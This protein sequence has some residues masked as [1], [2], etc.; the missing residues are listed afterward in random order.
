M[1]LNLLIKSIYILPFFSL[2][3]LNNLSGQETV[4]EEAKVAVQEPIRQS[5][6]L[7]P[8]N[9]PFKTWS[10]DIGLNVTNAQTDIRYK[11]FFGT[12]SPINEYKY[13]GQIRVTKMFDSALG[14]QAQFAYNRLQGVFDL[15]SQHQE[16]IN[17]M[18]DAGITEGIYFRNNVIQGSLNFYWNISNTIFNVNRFYRSMAKNRPM[19]PRWFSV[20]AYSGIGVSVFDPHVMR[21]SDNRT[22]EDADVFRGIEFQTAVTT[23]MVV[24][25]ALGAKFKL[26]K[27][28]DLGA[29]YGYNFVFTDKLDGFNHI[30]QGRVRADAYTNASLVLTVKLGSKKN[31]KDHIEWSNPMEPVFQD[32]A[33]IDALDKKLRKLTKDTDEDGVSD[34]FDKDTE[35]PEGATVGA[36]G[37]RLDTDAD[38][39]PD[40]MDMEMFTE[41]GAEVDEQGRALDTDGDGVP[42]YR[43]QE[44]GTSKDDFVNFQGR[45][46]AQKGV[47]GAGKD[48]K[49]NE[50]GG[51]RSLA[52][53]S[54]FFDSD[55]ATIKRE[56]ED[57][58]FQIALTVK[59]NNNLKLLLEGHC[60]ERG[61][62]EYNKDLGNRRA[63]AIKNY[64][65]ENYKLDA[66]IFT[67][68]SKGRAE[69]LSP[70]YNINRRVDVVIV[71]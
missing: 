36:N 47:N 3:P 24:P 20:Y 18:A 11:D 30:H 38:G 60:D 28:I 48:T 64:L 71:E 6:S 5:K 70:K 58:L 65:I 14:L 12:I 50:T 43:D 22:V 53:P 19:K 27:T 39:V 17:F 55:K 16:D 21:L 23:E 62:D 68:V 8:M 35:T 49:V 32:L 42:D 26:S 7:N 66:S 25:A 1:K 44:D 33:K 59:R 37:I 41:K 4:V 45:A 52:L 54:I 46:V 63:E 34:Y 57:E 29:E 56:F 51:L 31:A 61:S 2:L 15:N 69:A 13:G 10:V 40:D 9:K 67:I